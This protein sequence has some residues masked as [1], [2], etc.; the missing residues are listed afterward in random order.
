MHKGMR[1]KKKGIR[2]SVTVL[3]TMLLVPC[4]FFT[5]FM[6][7]LA[8]LKLFG[9]QGVM[10]ADTY[11]A[12][13][14]SEYD[15]YL[16][17]LYGLFAISNGGDVD[18]D[19]ISE[20][21]IKTY[22]DGANSQ[23][24]FMPYGNADVKLD[25]ECVE[26]SSLS[27][28]NILETQIADYMKY[29]I[30]VSIVEDTE[31][32]IL[33][34]IDNM[35]HVE[36]NLDVSKKLE[37]LT[38]ECDSYSTKAQDYYKAFDYVANT[39]GPDIKND[40][41]DLNT[42]I[43]EYNDALTALENLRNETAD[44]EEE[45]EALE[46]K[47]NAANDNVTNAMKAVNDIINSINTSYSNAYDDIVSK[48]DTLIS[49][50]ADFEA[51]KQAVENSLAQDGVN[52]QFKA[53]VEKNLENLDPVSEDDIHHLNDL[54]LSNKNS[55]SDTI[56]GY[57]ADG[58]NHLSNVS[59]D[60]WTN[61]RTDAQYQDLKEKYDGNGESEKKAKAKSKKAKQKVEDEANQKIEES[62]AAEEAAADAT[63]DIPGMYSSTAGSPI[64][65]IDSVTNLFENLTSVF[66]SDSG[67]ATTALDDF[68]LMEYD[69]GMFTNRTTGV[70][71]DEEGAATSLVGY[72]F[73]PNC[74]YSY[75]GEIEYLISGHTGDGSAKKNL[76]DVRNRIVAF[77][78]LMNYIST[79]TCSGVNTA[80]NSASALGVAPPIVFA[81]NQGM[82]VS[83]ATLESYGDWDL[84][85]NGEKTKLIKNEI[86]DFAYASK[87]ISLVDDSVPLV[88][89]AKEASDK[90]EIELDYEDYT[91]ILLYF[92]TN[93]DQ[94]VQRTGDLIEMNVNCVAQGVGESGTLSNNGAFQLD[95]AYTAVDASCMCQLPFAVMPKGF[96]KQANPDKYD[97]ILEFES[98]WY[99][100]TVTRS[101]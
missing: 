12:A 47:I 20:E 1:Y 33:D 73:S 79:Y 46:R 26:D 35:Q 40:L 8:R 97:E 32:G 70:K 88:D 86:S 85:K 39:D 77:R 42:K 55:L 49:A 23:K 84:L 5:G 3:V 62:N 89:E 15:G 60:V 45:Q 66:N 56:N 28:T 58:M 27:N 24:S 92:F 22:K 2:G 48:G 59:A 82:R 4:V 17:T 54:V 50:M 78:M 30:I 11:G 63:R 41:D 13:V 52:E 72:E 21:I 74:N 53:A 18:M 37:D 38:E 43:N 29:R 57:T 96:A 80:I 95:K 101:Y 71:S 64:G 90:S 14:L 69:F 76:A 25:Y 6:V 99:T 87:I 19:Q 61:I 34:A 98:R 16:Y 68:Y 94:R 31:G 7:D 91:K 93:R 83:L 65:T 44:T 36:E 10:A 9:N 75:L 81:L 51:K 67:I 100:Y